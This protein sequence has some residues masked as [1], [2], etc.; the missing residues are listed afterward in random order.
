[1]TNPYTGNYTGYAPRSTPVYQV[2]DNVSYL[3][4]NHLFNFG[5]NFTQVNAWSASA[6]SSLL[7][8]VTL[9]QATG[10][11][12]N[13]GATSLFTTTTLPGASA[14]QLER[15]RESLCDSRRPRHGRNQFGSS[16]RTE[17]H[18]R[19]ELLGGSR[20]HARI[21]RRMFRILARHL[22]T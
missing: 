18:L 14:T 19:P 15:C 10:D 22:A 6:N 5:F 21:R 3:K 16:R 11:P 12:D 13:T 7:N 20:S 9:G 1:M 8:T 2:N 17:P 4:K